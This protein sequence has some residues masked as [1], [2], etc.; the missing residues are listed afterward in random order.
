MAIDV[1]LMLQLSVL[2][3]QV[4]LRMAHQENTRAPTQELQEIRADS[5]CSVVGGSKQ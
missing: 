1:I 3:T 5:I 2:E 4:Q